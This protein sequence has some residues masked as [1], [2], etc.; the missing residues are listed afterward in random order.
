[1]SL[2]CLLAGLMVGCREETKGR[3]VLV[4][5]AQRLPSTIGLGLLAVTVS[6]IHLINK[7]AVYEFWESTFGYVMSL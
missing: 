4:Q 3:K 7:S 5:G 6:P 1:M 2:G